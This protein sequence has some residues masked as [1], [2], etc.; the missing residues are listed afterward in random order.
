MSFFFFRFFPFFLDSPHFPPII[1]LEREVHRMPP[2]NKNSRNDNRKE[3]GKVVGK[4]ASKTPGKGKKE[5]K[6]NT[7]TLSDVAG[8]KD[9]KAAIRKII[10]LLANHEQYTKK[11]IYIPKGLILQGPAG[12]GKTL[13]VKAIAGECNIPFFN[14]E[15]EDDPDN[16]LNDLKSV[17]DAAA[18]AK[19]S[20]VYID[21]ID[22]IVTNSR[23][24]SDLSRSVVQYLLTKLDS[25]NSTTGTM[26]IASTNCYDELPDS[27]LRSGRMDKKILID[28]PDLESRIEILKLY[29]KDNAIFK[30]IDT[31]VLAI[32]LDG[33]SGADIKT[34]INNTLIEYMDEDKPLAMEDFQKL[35]NEMHFE[36]IGKRWEDKNTLDRVLAHEIGHALVGYDIDGNTGSIS[37]VQYGETSGFT[38]FNDLIDEECWDESSAT[39]I[40]KLNM[41]KT[42]FL[43]EV[44]RCL[45]GRAAEKVY[46]G[47]F[48]T[49]CHSDIQKA[50]SLYEL[51]LE[52]ATFGFRSLPREYRQEY[53][54]KK[55]YTTRLRD[56][57]FAREERKA[58]RTIKKYRYLGMYLIDRAKEND[59]TLSANE[60]KVHIDF[61]NAH[62]KMVDADYRKKSL[63]PRKGKEKE[64]RVGGETDANAEGK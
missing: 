57:L 14:F 19:P 4:T 50:A 47:E 32:K 23:F 33:M 26:V 53:G 8:Y 55:K 31:R 59:D 15:M 24:S 5:I 37:G 49:G 61:Y 62:K 36:T 46:F 52:C 30:D 60:I 22:K 17:F 29:M 16:I 28:L 43:N 38:D 45:G 64:K 48:D 27:L 7:I 6:D 40:S 12:V 63:K 3:E 18:K 9:E 54:G 21:E 20:I 34:L 13:M 1:S 56:R 41:T 58:I 10:K 2:K 42:D 11:G 25:I 51:M 44:R 35:I 39:Q